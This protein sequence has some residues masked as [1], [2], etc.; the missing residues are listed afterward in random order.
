M[1]TVQ[2]NALAR[3]DCRRPD[4]KLMTQPQAQNMRKSG[5]DRSKLGS[6][7]T[8][9][10]RRVTQAGAGIDRAGAAGQRE[11]PRR[12]DEDTAAE[13]LQVDLVPGNAAGGDHFAPEI[14][15]DLRL[16]RVGGHQVKKGGC[17]DG[18]RQQMAAQAFAEIDVAVQRPQI[19]KDAGIEQRLR[20]RNADPVNEALL[21]F[22]LRQAP[23]RVAG[24]D[25]A[26]AQAESAIG[27]TSIDVLRKGQEQGPQRVG[28]MMIGGAEDQA[29]VLIAD[30]GLFVPPL[31]TERQP[32][33]RTGRE[34]MTARGQFDD[35]PR[36]LV[37]ER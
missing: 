19:E 37:V 6:E 8:G 2:R 22:A 21:P 26:A 13:L 3:L 14:E 29:V 33:P 34:A 31:R 32:A 12:I 23:F 27:E 5:V 1:Q 18:Q 7:Q 4:G 30:E 9:G 25:A 11:N 28:F 17:P 36:K 10:R 16:Q 35:T 20:F 24:H 15:R